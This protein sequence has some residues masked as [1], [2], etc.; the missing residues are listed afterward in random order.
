MTKNYS[1]AGGSWGMYDNTRNS[2]NDAGTLMLR[3]NGSDLDYY[4]ATYTPIDFL[5][6]GF[7]I[8]NTGGEDNAAQS[9]IYMAF[10]EAPFKYANA[11]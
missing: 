3:A 9:F 5:S 11:R 6:N 2:S 7:K 8:R 4:H 10:A 1:S